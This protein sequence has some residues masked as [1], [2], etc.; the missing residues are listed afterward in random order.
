MIRHSPMV[1]H[2]EGVLDEVILMS[3]L[4]VVIFHRLDVKLG[5]ERMMTDNAEDSARSVVLPSVRSL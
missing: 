5:M 2:A 1:E 4:V 3:D